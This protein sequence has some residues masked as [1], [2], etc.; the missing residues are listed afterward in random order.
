MLFRYE[1]LIYFI[2]LPP[3]ASGKPSFALHKPVS[4]PLQVTNDSV[5]KLV[6]ICLGLLLTEDFIR[7]NAAQ[8]R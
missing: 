8:D 2:R 3:C 1:N 5:I 6:A 4:T 7:S